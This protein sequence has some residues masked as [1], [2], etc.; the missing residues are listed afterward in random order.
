MVKLWAVGKTRRRVGEGA[1]DQWVKLGDWELGDHMSELCYFD[2]KLENTY[3]ST[4][5]WVMQI[6]T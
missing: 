4:S 6:L 2:S 1:G 3:K 5:E